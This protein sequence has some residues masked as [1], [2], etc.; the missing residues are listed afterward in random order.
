MNTTVSIDQELGQFEKACAGF[1]PLR[2]RES[3]ARTELERHWRDGVGLL[4]G[5]D[6]A[7]DL[8]DELPRLRAA[9]TSLATTWLTP[10]S[11]GETRDRIVERIAALKVPELNDRLAELRPKNTEGTLTAGERAEFERL[12]DRLDFLQDALSAAIHALPPSGS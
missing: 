5:L 1:D 6:R 9:M 11:P 7:G 10:R 3:A 8:L 2:L 12:H 4:T